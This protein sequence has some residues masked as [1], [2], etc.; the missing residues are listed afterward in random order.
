MN[1][2]AEPKVTKATYRQHS[3]RI[4]VSGDQYIADRIC[5]MFVDEGYSVVSRQLNSGFNEIP[6]TEISIYSLR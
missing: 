5:R 1:Y 3:A 2:E 4:E 6:R